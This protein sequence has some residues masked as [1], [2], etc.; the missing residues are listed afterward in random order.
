MIKRPKNLNRSDRNFPQMLKIRFLGGTREV[1]RSAIKIEGEKT[2]ILLD[3]GLMFNPPQL[4]IREN[5]AN[6]VLLSHAHL[7]HSGSIPILYKYGYRKNVYMTPPTKELIDLLYSD[8]LKIK[9]YHFFGREDVMGCMPL[10]KEVE[11]GKTFFVQEFEV[12]YSDA[13]HIPGSSMISLNYDGK[14]I[15]YTGDINTIETRLQRGAEIP[16]DANI[17]IIESTYANIDHPPREEVE[18]TFVDIVEETLSRSGIALIPAFAIGRSQEIMQVLERYGIFPAY[19]DGMAQEVTKI[20]NNHLRYIKSPKHLKKAMRHVAWVLNR[21]GRKNIIEE[22]CAILSTA[23]M[24]QGGPAVFYLKNIYK[25]SKSSLIFTGY[26]IE[27]TPGRRIL[28][29]GIANLNGIEVKVNCNVHYLDFSAH[30]GKRELIDIIKKQKDLERIFVVHGERD[31]TLKFAE[32]IY[33]ETGIPATAPELG[34]FF[35]VR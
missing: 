9:K 1:G 14:K 34:D 8:S 27:G 10:V 5:D 18:R 17:L 13:G 15:V 29:E 19:L 31:V 7:D 26:Q 32:E 28:D 21:R 35:E 2:S 3:Y 6:A 22:P 12:E 20:L 30:V 33:S 24:L 11:Y 16:R 23:G 4:P 25:D